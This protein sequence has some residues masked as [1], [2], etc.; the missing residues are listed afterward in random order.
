MDN[1]NTLV[2]VISVFLHVTSNVVAADA[3]CHVQHAD[4]ENIKPT[5]F[6]K[7]CKRFGS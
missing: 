3:H 4:S 6:A 1:P 5:R 2:I 7:I